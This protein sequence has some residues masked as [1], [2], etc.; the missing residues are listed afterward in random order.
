MLCIGWHVTE[1]VSVTHHSRCVYVYLCWFVFGKLG[2]LNCVWV[3]MYHKPLIVDCWLLFE[4]SLIWETSLWSHL[5][6]L[7]GW[8]KFIDG[9]DLVLIHV[10]QQPNLTVTL[11]TGFCYDW[12]I[13]SWSIIDLVICPRQ[14]GVSTW[15]PP[16]SLPPSIHV[17]KFISNS[18]LYIF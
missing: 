11:T 4:S 15:C 3:W 1:S 18:Q 14:S 2:Y 6:Q 10:I 13:K 16:R 12:Q 5:D 17:N 9:L 8:I 7:E